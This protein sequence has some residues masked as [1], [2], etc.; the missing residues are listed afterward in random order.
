MIFLAAFSG[1]F[2]G[3]VIS[4]LIWIFPKWMLEKKISNEKLSNSISNYLSL[5][6]ALNK[7]SP[8]PVL[9]ESDL[10]QGWNSGPIDPVLKKKS[11]TA[12]ENALR[13]DLEREKNDSGR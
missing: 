1:G 5:D 2:L 12:D 7:G 13:K 10:K 11:I 4:I 8:S 6:R 3:S 9:T